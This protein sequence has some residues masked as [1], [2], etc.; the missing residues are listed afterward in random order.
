MPFTSDRSGVYPSPPDLRE[1]RTTVLAQGGA[2]VAIDLSSVQTKA[3]LLDAFAR[4]LGFPASFGHN[5]D[6]LADALQDMSGHPANGYVL[7]LHLQNPASVERALGED[8]ATL[9]EVLSASAMY[10]KKRG[11]PFIVFADRL[12]GLPQWT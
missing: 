4:A 2:W 9:L 12:H 1:I 8:W 7:H 10:W 5:W 11:K 6:A 3:G